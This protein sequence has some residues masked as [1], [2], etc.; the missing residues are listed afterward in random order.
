MIDKI[1]VSPRAGGDAPASLSGRLQ[2]DQYLCKHRPRTCRDFGGE[3]SQPCSGSSCEFGREGECRDPD[4][5]DAGMLELPPVGPGHLLPS[6]V[7]QI[8]DSKDIRLAPKW[9]WLVRITTHC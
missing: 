2:D 7:G 1:T 8:E 3:L 5:S 6:L 4:L 9:L